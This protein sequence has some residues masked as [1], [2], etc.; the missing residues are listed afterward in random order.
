MLSL[1]FRKWT[2][3]SLILIMFAFFIVAVVSLGRA[4]NL[5]GE[6]FN[7]SKWNSLHGLWIFTLV[8]VLFNILLGTLT[9]FWRKPIVIILFSLLMSICAAFCIVLGILA[10]AFCLVHYTPEEVGCTEDSHGLV[11]LFQQIDMVYHKAND[12]LCSSTCPCNLPDASKYA[13]IPGT[14][15][16][17]SFWNHVNGEA[18]SFA[19]CAES[20]RQQTWRQLESQHETFKNYNE[21][22]FYNFFG[23]VEEQFQCTGWCVRSYSV[24]VPLGTN[25]TQTKTR[26]IIRYLFSDLNDQELPENMAHGCMKDALDWFRGVGVVLAIFLILLFVVSIFIIILALTMFCEDSKD[27]DKVGEAAQDDNKKE[28]VVDDGN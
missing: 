23:W 16:E 26:K 18:I 25:D 2:G 3:F 7:D 4:S 8:F 6:E 14:E 12:R 28:I 19:E 27:G 21:M 10:L 11:D 5:T 15:D 9:F 20:V 17:R 24:E 1:T 22:A 13:E